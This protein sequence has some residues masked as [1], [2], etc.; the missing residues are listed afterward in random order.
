[1]IMRNNMKYTIKLQIS[2]CKCLNCSFECRMSSDAV[3]WQRNEKKMLW[4]VD[5]PKE[6]INAKVKRID[7]CARYMVYGP[8]HIITSGSDHSPSPF[9]ISLS[10]WNIELKQRCTK[11][12]KH[13]DDFLLF[14]LFSLFFSSPFLLDL[15]P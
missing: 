2:A 10:L 9:A 15:F 14:Y 4:I 8:W 6:R 5:P 7:V 11:S 13:D 3:T 12:S 1:M